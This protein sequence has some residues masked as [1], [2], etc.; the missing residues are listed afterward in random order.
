MRIFVR[1][2]RSLLFLI[3][4]SIYSCESPDPKILFWYSEQHDKILEIEGNIWKFYLSNS[5]NSPIFKKISESDNSIIFSC[6][7]WF[8]DLNY[9]SDSIVCYIEKYNN[10]MNLLIEE[11]NSR[12]HFLPYYGE[13]MWDS[14]VVSSGYPNYI[15]Y[16]TTLLNNEP[17]LKNKN[18]LVWMV[19]DERY[20]MINIDERAGQKPIILE[21]YY[22]DRRIS[23]KETASLYYEMKFENDLS[24]N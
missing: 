6:E 20:K 9:N 22:N 5:N 7:N 14:I 8:C 15:K 16:D 24:F 13:I 23:R 17:D 4:L 10:E 1:N 12:Y 3:F 18:I 19:V 2:S 21:V 11:K